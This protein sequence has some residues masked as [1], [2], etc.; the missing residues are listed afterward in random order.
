MRYLHYAKSIVLLL[1]LF[2]IGK[3]RLFSCGHLCFETSR[4]G[5][6]VD[7]KIKDKRISDLENKLNTK[8][9]IISELMEEL[10]KEKKLAGVIWKASD[11]P[12][13]SEMKSW[14]IE[15]TLWAA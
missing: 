15:E 11:L 14:M 12:P 13:S 6:P 7:E 3:K 8:N 5:R 9:Q 4:I 10:L 1:G 2:I